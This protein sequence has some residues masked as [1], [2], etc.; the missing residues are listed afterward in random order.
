MPLQVRAAPTCRLAP[1][2]GAFTRWDAAHFLAAAR[3]HGADY[4]DL[5]TGASDN[6]FRQAPDRYYARDGLHLSGAGYGSWYD[7]LTAAT[8]L[9]ERL[10]TR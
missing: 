3:E 7:R 1:L 10:Q 4:V 5:F 8:A 9:P 6:G 2:L